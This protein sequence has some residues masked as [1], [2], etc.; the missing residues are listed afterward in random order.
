MRKGGREEED[1][2]TGA[3]RRAVP[4]VNTQMNSVA[5]EVG[6]RYL[7]HSVQV[8]G[9][10]EGEA[11]VRYTAAVLLL[12]SHRV[13]GSLQDHTHDLGSVCC[14]GESVWREGGRCSTAAGA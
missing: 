8:M 6:T 11:P 13:E 2:T 5:A 14:D 7:G 12:S 1:E 4:E 9:D 10:S 3:A